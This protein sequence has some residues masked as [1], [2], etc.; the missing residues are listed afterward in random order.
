MIFFVA[1][2]M[3][4][5]VFGVLAYPFLRAPRANP[6]SAPLNGRQREEL[7]SQRDAA[8]AAI[9]ELEFEFQ[10]GNLSQHD[11]DDLR[12]RY[13]DR[14]AG[15]LQQL[16]SLEREE[17]A[18]SQRE[19]R[20][21]RDGGTEDEIEQAVALLREQHE[22]TAPSSPASRGAT[23]TAGSTCPTCHETVDGGDRFCGNCGADQLRFCPACAA[24]REP[25]NRFCSRCGEE[26]AP[27]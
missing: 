9:R 18:S 11:Y 19:R 15:V 4:A 7:L 22:G 6:A 14:A 24:P 3:S 12:A 27:A 23:G 20:Q 16:D 2:L 25:A 26:L 13:R 17:A 8:Y 21:R 10:L 5:V 1:V